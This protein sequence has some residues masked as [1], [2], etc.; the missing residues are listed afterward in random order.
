MTPKEEFENTMYYSSIPAVAGLTSL[1][2]FL[3]LTVTI[4]IVDVGANPIDGV[5]PYAPLLEG[6]HA[7]VV[8]FEPNPEAL[9]EL[10]RNKGPR[11]VYLPHAVGD[12]GR[13]E[14]RFCQAAG[15]SS[16]LEP[17]RVPPS[18]VGAVGK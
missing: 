6:G 10:K 2:A 18:G 1:A 13:H 8:G 3:N 4:K 5:A 14:L 11:E 9:A 12:G 16:L 15:M 17:G 7:E